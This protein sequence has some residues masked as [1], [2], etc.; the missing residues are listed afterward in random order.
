MT[1]NGTLTATFDVKV[2]TLAIYILCQLD[3]DSCHML[4]SPVL[5]QE[6]AWQPLNYSYRVAQ[7][8]LLLMSMRK[9]FKQLF[10]LSGSFPL[11]T[12]YDI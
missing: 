10:G 2:V 7:T 8:Y 9:L 12:V 6:W 3:A 4:L 5:A 1:P 11:A